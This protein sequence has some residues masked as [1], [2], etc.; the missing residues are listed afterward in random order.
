MIKRY[1]YGITVVLFLF[2]AAFKLQAQRSDF[3]SWWELEVKKE[4]SGTWK[5]NAELEQRFH[6]NSLQY[7]RTLITVGAARSLGDY[8]ELAA[9]VRTTMSVTDSKEYLMSYR[10]QMDISGSYPISGFVFDLRARVQYSITDFLSVDDYSINSMV[11]RFRF[12]TQYHFFGTKFD[13]FASAELW[14]G[15]ADFVTYKP[16]AI[17]YVAGLKYRINFNSRLM[18]RYILEDEFNVPDPMTYHI[19]V[20]SYNHVF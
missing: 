3:Q 4:L 7:N 14:L 8:L 17:R 11:N 16:Y 9:G 12:K 20:M 19:L 18:L 2:A 15:V 10:T 6:K 1:S 5:L 13:A